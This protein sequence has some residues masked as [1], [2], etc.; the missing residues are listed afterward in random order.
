VIAALRAERD[1]LT[2]AIDALTAVEKMALGAVSPKP[3]NVSP[4]A[5]NGARKGPIVSRKAAIVPKPAKKAAP[6]NE[7]SH[8]EA[9]LAFL[10][11]HPGGQ[12]LSAICDGTG[13][14]K[15]S[16]SP[17]LSA[18]KSEG[19]LENDVGFWKVAK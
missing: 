10:K 18:L 19:Q 13:R 8:R 5:R 12:D 16:V 3:R 15:T 1:R 2:A 14:D 6:R 11:S 4:A 9:I 17:V 7:L